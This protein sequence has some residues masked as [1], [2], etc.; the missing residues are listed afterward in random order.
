MPNESPVN[1]KQKYLANLDRLE[2]QEQQLTEIEGLMRH[3]IARL[4]LVA[5]GVD[6]GMDRRLDELRKA[7]RGRE[8][9]TAI[10]ALIDKLA[11][12]TRS[13]E[14]NRRTSA[15]GYRGTQSAL[16]ALLDGVPF[17]KRMQSRVT[18]LRQDINHSNAGTLA[19]QIETLVALFCEVAGNFDSASSGGHETRED[20]AGNMPSREVLLE[21]MRNLKLPDAKND[22]L[23]GIELGIHKAT[24]E[25]ELRDL[26]KELAGYLG[27]RI[28]QSSE[29]AAVASTTNGVLLELLNCI[30][31]PAEFLPRLAAIK[32]RLSGSVPPQEWPDLLNAIAALIAEMRV[33]IEA[34]KSEMENFL[35][36]LTDRLQEL[37]THLHGA[38]EHRLASFKSGQE[39]ERSVK[40]EVTDM[41]TTVQQATSLSSLKASV[42]DRLVMIRQSVDDH[43]QA[44]EQRQSE[45]EARLNHVTSR[46]RTVE[47]ET[48][49]LRA[50]LH[51]RKIQ[52][53]SDPLTGIPNR[54][55]FED[56]LAREYGRWKRYRHAL[57]LMILDVD[58]FKQINDGYGHKAGDKALQL[59]ALVL[60]QNLR[61]T[62]FLARYGGEEFIALLP[63]TPHERIRQVAEKLRQAIEVSD[64]HHRGQRVPITVSCG[65][66]GFQETDTPDRV[67]QRADS[68]LYRAKAGGRNRHCD[69]N[70]A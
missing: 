54:T 42:Q 66:A 22:A 36:Q 46:L 35:R 2:K 15:Q 7:A 34:E 11:D 17:P 63:D 51:K 19:S 45:L 55:A 13:A 33:R 52:A 8:S 67:F 27:K 69:G 65:Y 5:Q 41:E 20:S 40:A 26:A 18:R 62:D 30:V 9:H 60:K 23:E 32:E 64:F 48:T 43:R 68:A 70:A 38:Q 50:H 44:E 58:H 4:C 31:L 57:T 29:I 14:P 10:R 24:I 25:R 59:I 16:T 61:E 3:G 37:E 21:F 49:Q 56:R 39:L 28:G 1:W 12:V 53:L 6:T 47:Q